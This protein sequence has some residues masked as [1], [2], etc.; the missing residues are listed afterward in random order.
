M[1][2]NH[3]KGRS[4]VI[5]SSQLQDF[6]RQIFLSHGLSEEH[7]ETASYALVKANLRGVDSHGV[8]RVPIRR[9]ERL[10][11]LL[12][13]GRLHAVRHVEPAERVD[14]IVGPLS[15]GEPEVIEVPLCPCMRKQRQGNDEHQCG[16]D[17]T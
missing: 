12:R 5:A 3:L 4:V 17:H 7:A 11:L 10:E 1:P 16:I 14:A 13:D 2:D 15:T 9:A 6:I 8:A